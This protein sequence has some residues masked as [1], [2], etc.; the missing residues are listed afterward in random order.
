MH[1][2]IRKIRKIRSKKELTT[3]NYTNYANCYA[4]NNYCVPRGSSTNLVK[5]VKFVVKEINSE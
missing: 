2:I 3:T 5:F 4:Q 1:R